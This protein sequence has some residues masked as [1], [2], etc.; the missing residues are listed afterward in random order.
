MVKIKI[1]SSICRTLVLVDGRSHSLG[2]CIELV[3][4]DATL[5]P[6]SM[7]F[8]ISAL[9]PHRLF[10]LLSRGDVH[11]SFPWRVPCVGHAEGKAEVLYRNAEKVEHICVVDC[12]FFDVNAARLLVDSWILSIKSQSVA[13]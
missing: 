12:N 11:A 7:R 2:L 1:E 6:Q 10:F 8:L 13:L 9:P 4:P 5:I 3:G